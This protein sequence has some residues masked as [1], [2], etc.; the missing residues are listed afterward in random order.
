M[1][2][3]EENFPHEKK[4]LYRGIDHRENIS[5]YKVAAARCFEI[6]NPRRKA[7]EEQQLKMIPARSMMSLIA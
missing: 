5:A 2:G 1:N 3:K 4:I 6:S 7:K